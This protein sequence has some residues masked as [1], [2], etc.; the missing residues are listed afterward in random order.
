MKRVRGLAC[1]FVAVLGAAGA[2]GLTSV[3]AQAA[4]TYPFTEVTFGPDGAAA[5]GTFRNVKSV[6]V[7]QSTGDVYAFDEPKHAIYKFDAT[8]EP[9]DFSST[10]TNAIEENASSGG[11]AEQQIAVD[12][13]SGPAKGDIY[14]AN[15]TNVQIYSAA[16][17]KIGQ[18]TGG[19][20]SEGNEACG[21]AV[22][23]TGAVYVGFYPSTV[24]KYVPA[25]NPVTGAQYAGALFGLS[26]VCNVA[27]DSQGNVYA[28]AYNGGVTRYEASQFNLLG[29][30]AIGTAI[31]SEKGTTLAVDPAVGGDVY[32]DEGSDVATYDASGNPVGKLGGRGPGSIRNSLG[33]AVNSASKQVYVG[34]GEDSRIEIFDPAV[35]VPDASLAP[36]SDLGTRTV[37]L[38]GTVDADAAGNATCVFE[39]GNGESLGQSA[40]C[41]PASISSGGGP[42]SVQATLTGLQPGATT[43]HYRLSATNA[44]GTEYSE[45]AEFTTLGPTIDDVSVSG[46][47]AAN[48]ELHAQ[49]DPHGIDTGYYFQ[50]GPTA[51]YGN[52]LPAAP[53]RDIGAGNVSESVGQRLEGLAPSATYHFSVV[54]SFGS[55]TLVSQDR[56]FT[57]PAGIGGFQ[58]PD[59]RAWEMVS[60]PRKYAAQVEPPGTEGG[61]IQAAA[62]GHAFSY[63]TNA[64]ISENPPGNP[65]RSQVFSA[66]SATGWSSQDI[67]P[68]RETSIRIGTG[69]ADRFFSSDLSSVISEPFI[70]EGPA[71]SE[72]VPDEVLAEIYSYDTSSG[73][74]SPLVTSVPPQP[75]G[76]ETYTGLEFQYASRDAK[77]VVFSTHLALTPEALVAPALNLPN[78]YEWSAGQGLKLVNVLPDGAATPGNAM[79][80]TLRSGER[81]GTVSD[82]GSHVVWAYSEGGGFSGAIYERDMDTG[83][84]VAVDAPQGGPGEAGPGVYRMTSTDGRRV[85]FTSPSELTPDAN[86]KGGANL[87]EFDDQTGALTDLSAD[88]Q[89]AGGG[90]AEVV[91]GIDETGTSVYY[92]A[93]GVLAPGA[94]AKKVNVYESHLEGGAWTTTFIATVVENDDHLNINRNNAQNDPREYIAAR[95]SP[96]GRYLAFTS[97]ASLTG[98]DNRDLVNGRRDEEV[99]LYDS[100]SQHL[101]CAS[102]KPT[103]E[104]PSG[105][106]VAFA[107]KIDFNGPWEG[108]SVAA[109]EPGWTDMSLLQPYYQPRYLSDSGRLFFDAAD[110]LVPH[111]SDGQVDVYEF[112]PQTAG[113][114]TGASVSGSTVFSVEADGCVGLISSGSST[115]ESIFLD[116]SEDGSDVFFMTNAKLSSADIDEVPDV[117]DAHACTSASPCIPQPAAQPPACTTAEACRAAPAPQPGIFGAPPSATFDGVGNLAPGNSNATPV[118]VKKK[119]AKPLTRAQRLARALSACKH[120]SKSRRAACRAQARKRYGARKVKRDSKRAN[121]KAKKSN[122]RAGR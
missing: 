53:G 8:G 67:S 32:V 20:R 14:L 59:G 90:E 49:I 3:P 81:I 73:A 72:D 30:G 16:G 50:Y 37:T 62:D 114:C 63:L 75:E 24:D 13:S 29:T 99:Y 77:H 112:E 107:S 40:P 5:T 47:S 118:Q 61:A 74:Y 27:P 6:T 60:P 12:E 119:K 9:V 34:A 35:T 54:V 69:Q 82:D 36:I 104:R 113:D 100:S 76:P 101:V 91:I 56:T 45:T 105:V 4:L 18:L 7:D 115:R 96:D 57:T 15:N 55:E 117:Y 111:D 88:S 87:Y 42:T 25:S 19:E 26:N 85:F 79:L 106:I 1:A 22:D 65:T 70:G 33:V 102:C 121:G 41:T 21:V 48:A 23:S 89:D 109:L 92:T 31:D 86:T 71:L 83:Q 2:L 66:R 80:G 93:R 103:G 10:G 97:S 44:N 122:G 110:A 95:V 38:H 84:T 28:A 98:Y 17:V 64:P 11:G 120:R 94:S 108:Q 52:T 43:Y 78:L 46:V 51:A 68:P 116:A 39:Y 58:M